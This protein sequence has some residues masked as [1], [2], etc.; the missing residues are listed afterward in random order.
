MRPWLMRTLM[1]VLMVMISGTMIPSVAE[2]Y[3][4]IKKKGGPTQKIPLDFPPEQIESF[5]VESA[6]PS[7]SAPSL[8]ERRPIEEDEQS[9]PSSREPDKPAPMRR[10]ESRPT[11]ISPGTPSP[12]PMIL[13]QKPAPG[14]TD[15]EEESPTPQVEQQT[16]V[17]KRPDRPQ[18]RAETPAA[19]VRRPTT[20]PVGGSRSRRQRIF[21]CKCI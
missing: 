6:G 12:Q 8:K 15:T 10:P 11:Q 13:R 5:Q 7:P 19:P 17:P 18:P 1:V 14:S 20:G 9:V 21:L 3:L 2:D 4:V 16:P